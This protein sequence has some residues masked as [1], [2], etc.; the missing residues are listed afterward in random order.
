MRKRHSP[1]ELVFQSRSRLLFP[2]NT[3]VIGQGFPETIVTSFVAALPTSSPVNLSRSRRHSFPN[4]QQHFQ[5]GHDTLWGCIDA[6]GMTGR[7]RSLDVGGGGLVRFLR[8]KLLPKVA[9]VPSKVVKSLI[10]AVYLP[11]LRLFILNPFFII[12][13]IPPSLMIKNFVRGA[14]IPVLWS[15]F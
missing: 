2:L 12:F 6:A 7:S 9:G 5:Y 4:W 14:H 13:S 8:D 10:Q 11:S 1:L 3:L 15:S